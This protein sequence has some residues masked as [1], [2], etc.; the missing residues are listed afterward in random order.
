VVSEEPSG[1]R[2]KLKKGTMLVLSP[3]CCGF[4]RVGGSSVA[5]FECEGLGSFSY[6]I[7]EREGRETTRCLEV[8]DELAGNF[9]RS[10]L[11]REG[12][13]VTRDELEL[14]PVGE[15]G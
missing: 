10:V 7:E 5:I 13:E 6:I 14:F 8:D 3:L 15:C 1:V 12:A 11:E 9:V 2:V 4:F